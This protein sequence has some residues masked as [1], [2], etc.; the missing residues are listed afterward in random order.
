MHQKSLLPQ[1]SLTDPFLQVFHFNFGVSLLTMEQSKDTSVLLKIV[2]RYGLQTDNLR[3]SDKISDGN[4]ELQQGKSEFVRTGEEVRLEL[5]GKPGLEEKLSQLS[6]TENE[7]LLVRLR[8]KLP[9][10]KS[11]QHAGESQSHRQPKASSVQYLKLLLSKP[12]PQYLTNY[13]FPI[14]T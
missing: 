12:T 6:L 1:T 5:H 7:M 3:A 13:S 8:R 14:S 4:L 9:A 11:G 2:N 10:E